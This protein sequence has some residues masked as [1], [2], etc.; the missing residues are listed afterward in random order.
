MKGF[1]EGDVVSVHV[2]F[3]EIG[4]SDRSEIKMLKRRGP[5]TM[6]SGTIEETVR[7]EK[8]EGKEL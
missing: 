3:E 8:K 5:R 1:K 7:E 6:P 2:K 4:K